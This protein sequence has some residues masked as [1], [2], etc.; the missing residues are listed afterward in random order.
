MDKEVYDGKIIG[1][2]NLHGKNV[3]VSGVCAG[4]ICRKTGWLS[5]KLIYRGY[6]DVE[7]EGHIGFFGSGSLVSTDGD[8]EASLAKLSSDRNLT[9]TI[10]GTLVPTAHRCN[11]GERYDIDVSGIK[12]GEIRSCFYNG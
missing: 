3:E 12:V 9:A 8:L 2:D 5:S 10:Q 11:N 1:S 7:G 6:L 4:V